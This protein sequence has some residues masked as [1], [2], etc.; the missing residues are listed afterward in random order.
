MARSRL[1]IA[2]LLAAALLAVAF[3]A[4]R[5][6]SSS[7]ARGGERA[8]ADER[9]GDADRA[10]G[11]V[12]E[13]GEEETSLTAER[14]QALQEARD[15]G[16]FGAATPATTAPAAG[17]LGSTLLNPS[18]DDWEPAVAADPRAPTCTC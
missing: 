3:G 1:V 15:Q 12:G 11:E 16:R 2:A 10:G 14:L 17:W 7:H 18:T 9:S 6:G 5:S 13:E 8:A 4:V